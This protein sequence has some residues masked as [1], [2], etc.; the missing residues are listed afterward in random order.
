MKP[1]FLLTVFALA[2]CTEATAPTGHSSP[3]LP[4]QGRAEMIANETTP[5]TN[6]LVSGC[7]NGEFISVSGTV[8]S[9]AEITKPSNGSYHYR[10]TTHYRL[11][12]AGMITGAIYEGYLSSVD[13][14]NQN[15]GAATVVD[16]S[17][18]GRL[19]ARGNVPNVA[20][21]YG[22]KLTQN[23]N[24]YVTHSDDTFRVRCQ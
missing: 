4:T 2:G 7:G 9:L 22:F 1:F 16:I 20:V 17:A 5:F 14:F 18:S 8:H 10:V 13:E 19:I 12:G 21:D 3:A 15:S 6:V 23:A 24:G 11:T